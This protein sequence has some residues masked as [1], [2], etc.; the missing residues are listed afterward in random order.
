MTG[1][2]VLAARGENHRTQPRLS[3]G[4]KLTNE[5]T[6]SV[7]IKQSSMAHLQEHLE[8]LIN[9]ERMSERRASVSEQVFCRICHGRDGALGGADDIWYEYSCPK[10]Q[11]LGDDYGSGRDLQSNS[12]LFDV[13]YGKAWNYSEELIAPCMCRGTMKYVHRSCLNNWRFSSNKTES[14]YQCDYCGGRY[15]LDESYLTRLLHTKRKSR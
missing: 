15:K 5:I 12:P 2:Q 7:L 11:E 14:F 1:F 3:I 6:R 4:E 13:D 10:A 9:L 8:K